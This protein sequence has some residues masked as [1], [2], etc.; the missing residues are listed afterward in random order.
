MTGQTIHRLSGQWQF[1][2]IQDLDGAELGGAVTWQL[3]VDESRVEAYRIYLSVGSDGATKSLVGG[4]LPVGT[5]EGLIPEGTDVQSFTDVAVYTKSS[6][7]EQTTPVAIAFSDTVSSIALATFPDY[8]LDLAELG[9]TL[10]WSPPTDEGQVTHYVVYFATLAGDVD[11][12]QDPNCSSGT[13][14]VWPG[15]DLHARRLDASAAKSV[16]VQGRIEVAVS[17]PEAFVRDPAVSAAVASAIA[18]IT[19][20]PP[21]YVAVNGSVAPGWRVG[22]HADAEH[23]RRLHDNGVVHLSYDINVP[24]GAL[25]SASEGQEVLSTAL[26]GE[27]STAQPDALT[28]LVLAAIEVAKAQEASAGVAGFAPPGPA[29]YALVVAA[30][31]AQAAAMTSVIADPASA[32]HMDVRAWTRGTPGPG[33][34]WC[35]EDELYCTHILYD[36][37]II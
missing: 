9:G 33:P 37:S 32:S 13:Q 29:S 30:V 25:A 34:T 20:V 22:S 14:L 2:C 3:P 36:H 24:M 8:D 4:D 7:V 35:R 16:R 10:L 28:Q 5:E 17:S 1:F 18:A 23:V 27:L 31:T 19:S 15:R 11:D 12:A 26:A 21:E 6:L